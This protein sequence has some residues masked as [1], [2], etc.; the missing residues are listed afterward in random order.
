[1]NITNCPMHTVLH[2]GIYSTFQYS[3]LADND[4]VSGWVDAMSGW[5]DA[6]S[7]WVEAVSCWI[8]AVSGWVDAVSGWVA[9][10][11]DN[12][13]EVTNDIDIYAILLTILLPTIFYYHT[14]LARSHKQ[15]WKYKFEWLVSSGKN[16]FNHH[17]SHDCSVLISWSVFI[18]YIP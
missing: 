17:P 9:T 12:T 4:A 14:Q 10:A 8:N 5:V 18:K 13:L 2:H 7:G 6:M 3:I 15:T 16:Y 1:M 11:A